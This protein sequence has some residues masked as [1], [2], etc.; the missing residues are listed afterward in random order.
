[1]LVS[2]RS[3]RSQRGAAAVTANYTDDVTLHPPVGFEGSTVTFGMVAN[4]NLQTNFSGLG[5]LASAVLFF[6]VLGRDTAFSAD[7]NTS[8]NGSFS[9]LLQTL[10]PDLPPLTQL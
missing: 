1:V 9:E 5:G 3:P 8:G 6:H 7:T 2:S 4:A 10:D